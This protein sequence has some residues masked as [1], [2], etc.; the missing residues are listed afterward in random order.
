MMAVA[1]LDLPRAVENSL[2]AEVLG[3]K[4]AQRQGLPWW[5]FAAKHKESNGSKGAHADSKEESKRMSSSDAH[6]AA[7]YLWLKYSPDTILNW[8][9]EKSGWLKRNVDYWRM[10]CQAASAAIYSDLLRPEPQS[11]DVIRD[12][13][14]R[15][16][17]NMNRPFHQ[18]AYGNTVDTAPDVQQWWRP[19]DV[20]QLDRSY[21]ISEIV[22]H[23]SSQ[24]RKISISGHFSHNDD[25][26]KT[27]V[28]EPSQLVAGVQNIRFGYIGSTRSS[29]SAAN[30]MNATNDPQ[31][32]T[33]HS[34]DSLSPLPA[35][36]STRLRC[37]DARSV[38]GLK[39]VLGPDVYDKKA[40]LPLAQ[41]TTSAVAV[42]LMGDQNHYDKML[43]GG[44]GIEI[45][46]KD[47][48]DVEFDLRSIHS[49][50]SSDK[51]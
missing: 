44:L 8:T 5:Y 7:D 2:I 38:I 21:I 1:K 48:S 13:S 39:T 29:F 42:R 24:Q 46:S 35:M 34:D 50:S 49:T 45:G 16:W 23:L 47:D 4:R 37:N 43:S 15:M 25:E 41:P 28:D 6:F 10:Y 30:A 33:V 32:H 11:A 40:P 19:E 12:R 27:D 26:A 20:E 9:P 3:R 22:E 14:V 31:S 17:I 18:Q 51:D 36:Q